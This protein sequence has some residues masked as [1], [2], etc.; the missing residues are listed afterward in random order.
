MKDA[1]PKPRWKSRELRQ[2]VV[3]DKRG[4]E[5]VLPEDGGQIGS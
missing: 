2:H 3:E 5:E 4:K 1:G